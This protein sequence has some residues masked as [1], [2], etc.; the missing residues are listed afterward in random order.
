MAEVSLI[1]CQS[2]G[3]THNGPVVYQT[4]YDQTRFRKFFREIVQYSSY[5]DLV[6]NLIERGYIIKETE[7]IEFLKSLSDSDDNR[8]RRDFIHSLIAP[9]AQDHLGHTYL[10]LILLSR[11]PCITTYVLIIDSNR[12]RLLRNMS[13]VKSSLDIT[14][15]ELSALMFQKKLLT[16]GDMEMLQ[17]IPTT[18]KKTIQLRQILDT[19]GPDAYSIFLECLAIDTWPPHRELHQILRGK[20]G[21]HTHEKCTPPPGR[22]SEDHADSTNQDMC[23]HTM[24]SDTVYRITT[25]FRKVYNKMCSIVQ[26]LNLTTGTLTPIMIEKNLLTVN[27]KEILQHCPTTTSTI[28]KFFQIIERKGPNACDLFLECLASDTNYDPHIELHRLIMI[29]EKEEIEIIMQRHEMHGTLTGSYYRETIKLLHK[30]HHS[31][32]WTEFNLLYEACIHSDCQEMRVVAMQ[33]RAM[34]CI[35]QAKWEDCKCLISKAKKICKQIP[36]SNQM[37][38]LGRC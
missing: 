7:W 21:L 37:F 13:L 29:Q 20:R 11:E 8:I 17:N 32:E 26:L 31:G 38:L 27:E 34:V 10:A 5:E 35:F 33:E 2:V 9:T 18:S 16:Q 36:G 14:A 3:I 24:T 30:Y 15:G 12:N 28:L 6:P 25:R 19:K 22:V 1:Q 4:I 23:R